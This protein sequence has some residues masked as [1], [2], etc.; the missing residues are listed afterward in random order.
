MY[1]KQVTF[2]MLPTH[3]NKIGDILRDMGL[4]TQVDVCRILL[5]QKRTHFQ[6]GEIAVTWKLAASEQVCEAWARQLVI[7]QRH[8]D[9]SQFGVDPWALR[10]LTAIQAHHLHALPLRCWGSHLI[11]ALASLSL[12]GKILEEIAQLSKRRY[13]YPCYCS[14]DQLNHYLN[15]YYP[16][17][18]SS[19]A[20]EALSPEH[21]LAVPGAE[22][23]FSSLI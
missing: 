8:V 14:G 20:E 7:S 17:P 21:K 6:F 1:G 3:S 10:Q 19:E 11:V 13:V 22:Q 15:Q 16:S 5:E 12:D 4:L 9:L 18:T 23:D 2:S